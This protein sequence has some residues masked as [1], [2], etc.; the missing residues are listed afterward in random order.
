MINFG[1]WYD[2]KAILTYFMNIILAIDI[3]LN[4]ILAGERLEKYSVRMGRIKHK[5]GMCILL[6]LFEKDHCRKSLTRW[7]E[8]IKENYHH[9]LSEERKEK[10]NEN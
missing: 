5:T 4:A 2:M 1:R 6:N 3:L 7:R 9:V 8:K 10:L